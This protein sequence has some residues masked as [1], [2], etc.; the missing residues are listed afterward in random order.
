MDVPNTKSGLNN[1][2]TGEIV[3]AVDG[4]MLDLCQD[5]SPPVRGQVRGIHSQTPRR[6]LILFWGV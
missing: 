2:I 1:V 4:K 3:G 5:D 6:R